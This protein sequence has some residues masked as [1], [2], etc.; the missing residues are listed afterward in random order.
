M[1]LTILKLCLTSSWSVRQNFEKG[2]F[3]ST[4]NQRKGVHF[5]KKIR[6]KSVGFFFGDKHKVEIHLSTV[7]VN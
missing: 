2:I 7:A 5:W 1:S 4:K 3:V 6:D